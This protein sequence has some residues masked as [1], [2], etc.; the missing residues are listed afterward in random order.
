MARKRDMPAVVAE[1]VIV[2]IALGLAFVAGIDR[3]EAISSPD[4]QVTGYED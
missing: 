3:L 1:A 4:T 2:L